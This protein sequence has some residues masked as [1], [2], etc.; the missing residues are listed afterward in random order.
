MRMRKKK[1]REGRMERCEAIWIKNPLSMRGNWRS[2][3]YLYF[4]SIA[5]L[6]LA[7][8]WCFNSE[9]KIQDPSLRRIF[10]NENQTEVVKSE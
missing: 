9:A 1:N 5:I 10:C 2:R 8:S 7:I 3:L 4:F 6:P